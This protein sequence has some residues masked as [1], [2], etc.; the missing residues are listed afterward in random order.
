MNRAEILGGIV[1]DLRAGYARE[2]ELYRRVRELSRRQKRLLHERGDGFALLSLCADKEELLREIGA[3]DDTLAPAR[4]LIAHEQDHIPAG[5]MAQLH[6]LLDHLAA[7]I[8]EIRVLELDC[9][10][11]IAAETVAPRPVGGTP[12][13]G[14]VPP[15]SPEASVGTAFVD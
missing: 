14:V 6:D 9:Y 15:N 10:N 8:E 3:L 5:Q 2:I 13:P 7:V 11:F 12:P 1:Q 4:T